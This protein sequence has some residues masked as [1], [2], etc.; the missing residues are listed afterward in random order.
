[1][2]QIAM[3]TAALF[4]IAVVVGVG[5]AA[6]DVASVR[7]AAE[8]QVA[9]D[10]LVPLDRGALPEHTEWAVSVRI[11]PA[12][13]AESKVDLSRTWDGEIVAI[14]SVIVGRPIAE[15]L[16]DLR[17]RKPTQPLPRLLKSVEVRTERYRGDQCA[18]L[19][20]LADALV[21]L[22]LKAVLPTDMSLDVTQYEF[23]S[24]TRTGLL[25]M[26]VDSSPAQDLDAWLRQVEYFVGHGCGGV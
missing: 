12:F 11:R 17:S 22:K 5:Q 18:V 14:V 7:W 6:N 21:D 16:S 4:W 20:R 23:V 3:G 24:R 10:A 2:V 25:E 13:H 8:R 19:K 15:Q 1:M 9:L 26:A